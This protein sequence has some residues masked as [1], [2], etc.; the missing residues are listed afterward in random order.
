MFGCS[1]CQP[2][3]VRRN[4]NSKAELH[5]ESTFTNPLFESHLNSLSNHSDSDLKHLHHETRQDSREKSDSD[6]SLI[7]CDSRKALIGSHSFAS[8]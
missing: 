4:S 8:C 5:F 1:D 6:S 3:V 2:F 7:L